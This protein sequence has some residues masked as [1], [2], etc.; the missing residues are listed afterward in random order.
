M[1]RAD[2]PSRERLLVRLRAHLSRQ[3][4]P[5]LVLSAILLLTGA[6]GFLASVLLLKCGLEPMW[7]RYPLAVVFA[8][9]V[10]LGLVRIWAER[11]RALLLREEYAELEPAPESAAP[12]AKPVRTRRSHRRSKRSGWDWLDW[13]DFGRVDVDDAEGCVVVLV[14]ITAIALTIGA[15]VS[16]AALIVQAEILLAEVLLD[17]VLVAAFQRRLRRLQPQWWVAGVVRQTIKPVACTA[18]LLM[19]I[20]F[21]LQLMAPGATS[22]GDVWRHFHPPEP[23]ALER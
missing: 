15:L 10:F 18:A 2:D 13:L 12:A 9:T 7:A 23:G 1:S 11:E 5:R 14:V 8:W 6:V 3:R 21:L 16:V 19:V 17:A 4:S 22:V 20:G